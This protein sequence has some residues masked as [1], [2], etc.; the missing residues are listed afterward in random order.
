[1]T[2]RQVVVIVIMANLVCSY[3][4]FGGSNRTYNNNRN[5]NIGLHTKTNLTWT[6]E[7]I[8]LNSTTNP[9]EGLAGATTNSITLKS[10]KNDVRTFVIHL[11]DLRITVNGNHA[12]IG[13]LKV[14]MK[15]MDFGES[16]DSITMDKIVAVNGEGSRVVEKKKGK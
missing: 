13:D 11:S 6:V 5:R 12:H 4:V 7:S 1:M 9:A 10:S 8:D 16:G 3:I 2:I 14:G 15:V